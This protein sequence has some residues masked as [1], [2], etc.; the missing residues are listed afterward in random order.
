MAAAETIHPGW[1]RLS[2]LPLDVVICPKCGS[3]Q[4]DK[5]HNWLSD[6]NEPTTC[7]RPSCMSPGQPQKTTQGQRL[8]PPTAH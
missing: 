1:L 3:P 5:P 2:H 7:T 6:E 8:Y 4:Q